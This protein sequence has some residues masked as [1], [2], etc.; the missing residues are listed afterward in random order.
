MKITLPVQLSPISRRRDRSVKLSFDTRELNSSE[1][2]SLMAIEGQE[3]W[4]LLAPNELFDEV[5]EVNADLENK[6]ESQR[7]R[8][9]LYL[10][11]KQALKKGYIGTFNAYYSQ[12]MERIIEQL[13]SK[14]E[15]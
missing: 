4:L 5:P 12:Q 1:I 11:Y 2:L 6:T 9:V 14:I 13:K 15:S 3:M 10:L 8:S 7:Q